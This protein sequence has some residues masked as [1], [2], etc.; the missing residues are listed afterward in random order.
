MKQI[1]V[2]LPMLLFIGCASNRGL[3]ERLMRTEPAK[4]DDIIK[5]RHRYEVQILYTQIDRDENNRPSFKSFSFNLDSTEYFYPASTVK[6]PL[7][8]LS[9]EKLNELKVD[10]LDMNTTIFHDSC[11]SG[12]ISARMDS[13]SESGLP[14]VSH[15]SKKILVVSDNDAY[16]RLY[17]FM[18]QKRVNQRMTELGFSDVRIIHRLER[19]LSRD[20]NRHTEAVRF[21]DGEKI[22]YQQ[23]MLVNELM[24]VR[25]P[26][27]KGKGFMR[28]DSVINKS[29]DFT[30]KNF[31]PLTAQQKLLKRIVFPETTPGEKLFRITEEQ[32]KFVLKYMSQLP[33]ETTFPAYYRD[34]T[35][36]D[37][38]C[39]FLMYGSERGKIPDH[40]RI[41]NK[42]GDA[43]GYLIDNAYIVDFKNNV[44]FMLSAVINT[45]VDEIYND[46]K[47]EYEKLGFPFMKDLGTLIYQYELK[48]TRKHTP[49]LSEFKMTYDRQL[50]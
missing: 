42:V 5:N 7:V 20:Q 41:F 25:K 27:Y 37:A 9:F 39:K 26:V 49:D 50:R 21:L 23:P 35:Y 33:G 32:R 13:T 30:Y 11:Y 10:G 46:G 18:G 48:R 31:Y 3:V 44:E 1:I 19:P 8:L 24:T 12:Q 22:I 15:Y 28:N 43:Y 14:S 47:Y 38:Y 16:N 36:Y 2:F 29:F 45:N 17:E 40:I 6:L 4:F 34:T